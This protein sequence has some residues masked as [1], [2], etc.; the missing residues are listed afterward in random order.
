MFDAKVV[1]GACSPARAAPLT[2]ELAG[3]T[4]PRL[5]DEARAVARK[6]EVGVGR[7]EAAEEGEVRGEEAR[8]ERLRP[9]GLA[10]NAME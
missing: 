2:V 1:M 9:M 6:A 7:G 3:G 10:Q 8:L 4:D 5:T